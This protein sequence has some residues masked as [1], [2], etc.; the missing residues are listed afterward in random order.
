MGWATIVSGGPDGRYTIS[1]DYGTETRD[2]I[3]SALNTLGASLDI[4]IAEA[5]AKVTEAEEKEAEQQ[6][7]V[8]TAI[9]AYIDD[10]AAGINVPN[11]DGFNSALK[12]FASIVSFNVPAR[13]K[14]EALKFEKADVLRRVAQ[15]NNVATSTTRQAW[16]IDFTED[17]AG[18]VATV[19][20]NGESDLVLIAAGGRPWSPADG[21]MTLRE[22]QS[23]EQV[24]WNAA[25]L[26]GWQKFRPTFRW[27][28]ITGLKLLE[29]KA[30]VKLGPAT[31]SAQRL[32]INQEETL[33]DIPVRYMNCDA[34]AF[35]VDDRVIVEFTGQ[36]WSSAKVVGFLEFPRPCN[37]TCVRYRF[38]GYY[39]ENVLADLDADLLSTGLAMDYRVDRGAWVSLPYEGNGGSVVG[40][41]A[42]GYNVWRSSSSGAYPA[43]VDVSI[44][45]AMS[46]D[47]TFRGLLLSRD[48]ATSGAVIELRIFLAGRLIANMAISN[49]GT[50]RTKTPGGIEIG[51]IDSD[52]VAVL[53]YDLFLRTGD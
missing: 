25:V 43:G 29:N 51:Y 40:P 36:E 30:T 18:N 37:W 4:Q 19:D 7:I 14:L 49:S 46:S 32:G 2:A 10:L 12:T 53:D 39:F 23:P 11:I 41:G 6:A 3:L 21:L 50:P 8:D 48:S 9:Q 47:P 52:A 27:G 13:L 24:F 45:S 28:T 15:W 17:A 1:I 35:E 16:C 5:Q 38:G 22:I 33:R 26:P 44:G 31:S 34:S 42:E 20:V